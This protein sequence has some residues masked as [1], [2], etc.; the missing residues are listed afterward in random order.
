MISVNLLILREEKSVY[1]AF[2]SKTPERQGRI[3]VH[4]GFRRKDRGTAGVQCP[5]HTKY[6]KNIIV[7]YKIPL[8]SIE[9]N[10]SQLTR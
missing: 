9:D 8:I 1:S 5:L 7:I 4:E 10:I 6:W 3:I 2:M